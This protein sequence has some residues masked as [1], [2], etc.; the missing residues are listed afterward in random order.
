[1]NEFSAAIGLVQLKKLNKLNNIRKKIAKKYYNKIEIKQKMPYDK[2]SVYHFYWIL[3]DKRDEF[4]VKMKE[5]GIET[6][7]H[8]KP[9]HEFSMYKTPKSLPI[10]EKIGKSIVTIP[11]HPNLSNEEIELIIKLVNKFA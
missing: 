11:T 9:I 1:M 10:T 5:G 8:Y 3:V 2:D 4:R 6:G 7:T